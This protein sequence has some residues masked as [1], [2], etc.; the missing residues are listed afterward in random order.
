[1]NVLLPFKI[2]KILIY[3]IQ[4]NKFFSTWY[5]VKECDILYTNSIKSSISTLKK[6]T[7]TGKLIILQISYPQQF[8]NQI[9]E[10]LN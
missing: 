5:G 3:Y 4:K 8:T 10:N 7:L 1:M 6:I 2:K 9:H